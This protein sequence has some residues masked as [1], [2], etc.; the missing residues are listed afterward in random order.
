MHTLCGDGGSGTLG[1]FATCLINFTLC[2]PAVTHELRPKHDVTTSIC[3]SLILQ[4]VSGRIALYVNCGNTFLLLSESPL[5]TFLQMRNSPK[6]GA[7]EL[8]GRFISIFCQIS[9]PILY[10]PR[11]MN[12]QK[13]N[14]GSLK[15]RLDTL[16]NIL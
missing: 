5:Q 4:A 10:H 12:L 7:G 3:P 1:K 2:E 16:S 15:I 6:S 8:S 11:Q 13:I 9:Y 14:R